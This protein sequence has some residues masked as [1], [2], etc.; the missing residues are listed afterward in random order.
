MSGNN[1][2]LIICPAYDD[3]YDDSNLVDSFAIAIGVLTLIGSVVTYFVQKDQERKDGIEAKMKEDED[4][5]REQALSRVRNQLA[6]FVGP[7]HRL[8]K[9][10]GTTIAQY[11][12][13]SGHGFEHLMHS[14]RTKGRAF[15]MTMMSEEFVLPFIDNPDSFEAVLYR[16]YCER[17]LKPTY[18]KIRDLIERQLTDL[19]DM[20]TQEE[21]LNRYDEE[22]IM[23]PYNGSININVIFD[24]Y[25]VWTL[26]FDDIMK[27]WAEGDFR[28][29]QPTTKVPFL[30]CNDLIDLLYENA[31]IK[32]SKYN[33]HVSVHKN[34][35]QKN[36]VVRHA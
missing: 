13:E 35:I 9:I 19:A 7:M 32:E 18:T 34:S 4:L 26:E 30:V 16:N 20:P 36:E 5:D 11:T 17:R 1:E 10:Q 31:K 14:A 24:S 6:I 33:K 2:T 21:W 15:W 23:S 28:R 8:W 12:L 22:D 29:M 3:N 27:S 25:A